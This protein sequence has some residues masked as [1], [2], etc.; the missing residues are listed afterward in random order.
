MDDEVLFAALP[1]SQ[2]LSFNHVQ[3]ST[4]IC[5]LRA[6]PNSSY[7]PSLSTTTLPS[8]SLPPRKT[9]VFHPCQHAKDHASI[10]MTLSGK[11][12]RNGIDYWASLAGKGAGGH[13]V[14]SSGKVVPMGKVT[15]FSVSRT[16]TW[17]AVGTA[18]GRIMIWEASHPVRPAARLH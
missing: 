1:A 7:L 16:G 12:G 10:V 17:L 14:P 6:P 11:D 13:S 4:H 3:T 15:V 18:D 8:S 9:V 5:S 2:T